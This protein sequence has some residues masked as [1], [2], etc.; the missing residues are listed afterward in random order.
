MLSFLI[1]KLLCAVNGD[2]TSVTH[3][4]I[5]P[6]VLALRGGRLRVPVVPAPPTRP[7]WV[8]TAHR[9]SP[10]ERATPRDRRPP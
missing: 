5:A 2:F 6:A 8:L 1:G 3:H 7:I 4:G 10:K 9:M